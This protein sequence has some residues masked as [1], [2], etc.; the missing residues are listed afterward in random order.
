[1]KNTT[2]RYAVLNVQVGHPHYEELVGQLRQ[3]NLLAEMWADAEHRLVE[4]P[5]K[6][7][8]IVAVDEGGRW[9]TA[10]WAASTIDQGVLRC[11]DNYERRGHGRDLSLYPIAYRHRHETVVEPLGLPGLTYLFAQPVDLHTADGWHHTGLSGTSRER[12]VDAHDW[13]ELRR[14]GRTRVMTSRTSKGRDWHV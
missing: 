5:G 6:I 3:P 9:V 8:T 10:A 1:V 11:S 14:P 2:P 4:A 7:W 12:E 13:W